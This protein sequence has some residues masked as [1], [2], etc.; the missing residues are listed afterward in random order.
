MRHAQEGQDTPP[1]R[2]RSGARRLPSDWPLACRVL[3]RPSVSLYSLTCIVRMLHDTPYPE[4][5]EARRRLSR[6]LECTPLPSVARGG[7][8]CACQHFSVDSRSCLGFW[9]SAGG[10]ERS[11]ATVSVSLAKLYRASGVLSAPSH[12]LL[13]VSVTL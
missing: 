3:S 7:A 13:T 8:M 12:T 9:A 5:S 10:S 6:T 2:L 11:V 4:S 1:L